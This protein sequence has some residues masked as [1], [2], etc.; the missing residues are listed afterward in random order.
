MGFDTSKIAMLNEL[1]NTMS[2]D[3]V[4]LSYNGKEVKRE[5]LRTFAVKAKASPGWEG[6]VNLKN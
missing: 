5:E 4:V 6:Y 2:F 3:D 1:E